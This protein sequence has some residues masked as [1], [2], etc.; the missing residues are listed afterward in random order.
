M[1]AKMHER[2]IITK[3]KILDG[4]EKEF[5][6]NVANYVA[7]VKTAIRSVDQTVAADIFHLAICVL[8]QDFPDPLRLLSESDVKHS[9][10][11]EE[12][13]A[14]KADLLQLK[15]HHKQLEESLGSVKEEALKNFKSLRNNLQQVKR[16]MTDTSSLVNELLVEAKTCKNYVGGLRKLHNLLEHRNQIEHDR[17][18]AATIQTSD[19]ECSTTVFSASAA[20]PGPLKT[21]R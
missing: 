21:V 8:S 10:N 2:L 16:Q 5:H 1:S 18:G 13:S 3:E 9:D 20:K 11:D 17:T 4:L 15:R 12:C 19:S 7:A 14:I 6:Q